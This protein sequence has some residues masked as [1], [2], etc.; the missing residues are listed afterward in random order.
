MDCTGSVSLGLKRGYRFS[1]RISQKCLKLQIVSFKCTRHRGA[2]S[3][4]FCVNK[5][6]LRKP[7]FCCT[8]G[9]ICCGEMKSKL[10]STI[11]GSDLAVNMNVRGKFGCSQ[12]R[13]SFEVLSLRRTILVGWA[14]F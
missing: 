10:S 4:S 7:P 8:V 12:G 11:F 5:Q 1:S 14:T 3:S 2:P 9:V 13:H 6:S